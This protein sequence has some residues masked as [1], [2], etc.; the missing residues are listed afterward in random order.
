ML[1]FVNDYSE[2]AHPEILRR[3]GQ[4]NF[5]QTPGY[6]Q[7]RYSES[8]RER[9]RQA[10]GRPDA[11]V[12]FISGGTQTNRLVISSM[13]RPYQGVVA[14]ETGHVSA[15][16]AGA[17]EGSGHKVLTI[18]GKDAKLDA[19][20]LRSFAE[21]F[22]ADGNYE[23][24]VFPG[25]VYISQPSEYGTLYSKSELESL[26]SVCREYGMILYMDGA[27]LGYALA[28][29]EN[30]LSLKDIAGLTDVFFIGGTKVGALFGEAVVFP[31]GREPDHFFTMIKQQ[32]ALLAKGRILG[33]QFDTLFTDGLYLR[34]SERAI[35]TASRIRDTLIKKGYRLYMDSP[36][37]QLFIVIEN[38]RLRELEKQVAVSFM[39]KYDRDHTVVRICT[40]WATTDE[41]T[42]RLC[43]L[44]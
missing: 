27:R 28:C 38:G 34:I 33:L 7:D 12:Y 42:D 14:A 37:N 43:E 13:L 15:H 23:H 36:T 40:G 5:E 39:N 29:P 9:I 10:V 31:G 24:M 19:G 18:P 16:E 2:G 20:D 22:Y 11:G 44:L 35:E 30:D 8:A 32:G 26:Y 4:T 6:G 1:Y 25:M 17:I 21:D 41:D 3:L